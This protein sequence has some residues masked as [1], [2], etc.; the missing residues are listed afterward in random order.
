MGQSRNYTSR[1][2]YFFLW[3]IVNLEHDFFVQQRIVPQVKKVEHV[4]S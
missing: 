1:G 4:C 2:L 3:K